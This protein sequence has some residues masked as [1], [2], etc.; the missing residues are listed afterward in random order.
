M[1]YTSTIALKET[2]LKALVEVYHSTQD[3]A[4][5]S[6]YGQKVADTLKELFELKMRQREAAL[7]ALEA[8]LQAVQEGLENQRRNKSAIVKK[9]LT[10]L[11]KGN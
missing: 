6:L 9:R 11:L 4:E 7:K 5:K 8:E 3:P 10:E 2:K 1:D